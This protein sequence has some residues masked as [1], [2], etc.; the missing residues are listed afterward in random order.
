MTK[1]QKKLYYKVIFLVGLIAI[2]WE[3]RIYRQTII[4]IKVLFGIIFIIGFLTMFLTL[5][6]FKKLFKYSKKTSLYFYAF[7][8]SIVSW[9]FLACSIFMFTNYYLKS[10]GVKKQTFKIVERSS[11]SGGRRNRDERKPMFKIMYE[12]ELKELIFTHKYYEK[13]ESYKNIELIVKKGFLGYDLLIDQKL[14]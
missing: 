3:I 4:D 10:E 11:L 6:D 9:G 14:K 2:S 5:K 13:M 12:G 7:I 8:Q 1:K